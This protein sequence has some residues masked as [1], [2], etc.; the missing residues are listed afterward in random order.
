MSDN[1]LKT[2]IIALIGAMALMASAP[3][4][5]QTSTAPAADST[6]AAAS[7][8][9]ADSSAAA[10]ADSSAAADS[11]APATGSAVGAKGAGKLTPITMFIG[12]TWVVKTVILGLALCSVLSWALL[13][14]KI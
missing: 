8:A 14:T 2:P 10:P 12:A 3:A 5:A 11:S 9:P 6:A 1:K 4:F 7:A 13:V